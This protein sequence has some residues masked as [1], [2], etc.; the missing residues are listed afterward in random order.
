MEHRS[1][2]HVSTAALWTVNDSWRLLL[3]ELATDTHV[4]IARKE[5]ASVAR[6]G[7]IY[8]VK[9]GF[10]IDLGYQARLNQ[11]APDR[12][13]LAGVTVRW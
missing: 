1:L 6:L 12:A 9:K 2:Y 13:L 11:A 7:A 4:D 10:D 5:W 8:T 3:A